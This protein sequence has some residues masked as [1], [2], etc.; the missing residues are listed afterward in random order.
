M[1]LNEQI[2]QKYIMLVIL[3]NNITIIINSNFSVYIPWIKRHAQDGLR[4]LG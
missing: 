4:E 2:L 3:R 1:E